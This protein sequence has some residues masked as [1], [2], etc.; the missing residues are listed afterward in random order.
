M[1]KQI[2]PENDILRAEQLRILRAAGADHVDE[3]IRHLL[4]TGRLSA[5]AVLSGYG[6]LMRDLYPRRA[7]VVALAL[8]GLALAAGCSDGEAAAPDDAGTATQVGTSTR[9]AIALPPDAGSTTTATATATTTA[10]HGTA[11]ATSTG[12]G[13]PSFTAT[14]V[15]T[16]THSAT[17]TGTTC[18]L[19]SR[20]PI[21][22]DNFGTAT[23]P[24]WSCACGMDC[25]GFGCGGGEVPGVWQQTAGGT[26]ICA[27]TRN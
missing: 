21:A 6:R 25:G 10:T 19:M 16:A 3:R 12:T 11:T 20:E 2:I 4:A 27:C 13:L 15:T 9:T 26:P 22:C 8:L 17:G 18:A 14:G 24:K 23:A 5:S 1:A 7:G